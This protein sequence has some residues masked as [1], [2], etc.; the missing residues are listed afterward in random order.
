MFFGEIIWI[1]NYIMVVI[2]YV[3]DIGV[4]IFFFWMFE[5]REK[6]F[7]FYEWVFGVWMYVVYI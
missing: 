7:E 4:M 1:L 3:L 2:I 6:M 5:E